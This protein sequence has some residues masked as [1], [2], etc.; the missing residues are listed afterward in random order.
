MIHKSELLF[1]NTQQ[2]RC[3]N[4]GLSGATWAE[5]PESEH[6]AAP[7]CQCEWVGWSSD[8]FH[9]DQSWGMHITTFGELDDPNW[10]EHGVGIVT[11]P[12]IPRTDITWV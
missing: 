1:V 5:T 2:S 7:D 12:F 10:T 9:I 11:M 6:I 3:G 4:C 8:Y